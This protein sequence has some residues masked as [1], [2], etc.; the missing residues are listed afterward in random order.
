M[1]GHDLR[2]G[3]ESHNKSL[4]NLGKA[5][6]EE[7]GFLLHQDQQGLLPEL[8]KHSG[9]SSQRMDGVSCGHA[10]L[11]S[12]AKSI[13]NLTGGF[14]GDQEQD[15]ESILKSVAG[16]FTNQTRLRLDPSITLCLTTDQS[17]IP[18]WKRLINYPL[19]TDERAFLIVTIFSDD[20][21]IEIVGR[22][23]GGDAQAFVDTIDEASLHTLSPPKSWLPLKLPHPVGQVLDIVPSDIR[24]R[25]LQILYKIC[26]HQALLPRSL[27][28]PLCYDP[29]GD[30]LCRGRFADVWEG[31]HQGRNVA[32]KVLR[33][34]KRSDLERIRRVSRW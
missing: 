24:R 34:C 23:S 21:E 30:P 13:L 16:M 29:T 26:G 10:K 20:N 22:L 2:I 11:R 32:S 15:V 27:L 18:T 31:R 1:S 25:C 19:T 33:I 7:R 4:T 28:I 3:N 12:H 17:N 14:R 9:A 8:E 5:L 6:P